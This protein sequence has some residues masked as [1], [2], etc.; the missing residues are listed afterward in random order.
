MA[1]HLRNRHPR[2]R[3]PLNF[4]EVLGFRGRFCVC[5][6]YFVNNHAS[7]CKG[8]PVNP[9]D[10]V[11]APPVGHEAK[12]NVLPHA[13]PPAVTRIPRF[14]VPFEGA[15]LTV[16]LS[17]RVH[18]NIPPH[19]HQVFGKA[20]IASISGFNTNSLY[21]IEKKLLALMSVPSATLYVTPFEPKVPPVPQD[22]RVVCARRAKSYLREGRLSK[23]TAA[24]FQDRPPLVTDEVINQLSALHPRSP[25]DS[26]FPSLPD[27]APIIKVT[28]GRVKACFKALN[29]D[30]APGCSA[31]TVSMLQ[32]VFDD[33]EGRDFICCVLAKIINGELKD[34]RDLILSSRLI[35]IAKPNGDVRPVAVGETLYK[36]AAAF[37]TYPLKEALAQIFSDI[38]FAYGVPGG[39]ERIVHSMQ[40]LAELHRGDPDYCIASADISNAFNSCNRAACFKEIL[41]HDSLSELLRI[42]HFAYSSPSLLYILDSK[43]ATR[44]LHSESGVKQGDILGMILF[45]LG[46]HPVL[47][48]VAAMNH[49]R[50]HAYADDPTF[51][52]KA[53]D[54]LN[55]VDLLE[56]ECRNKL[57]L[58]LNKRKT[59]FYF[60]AAKSLN[61]IS[62]G[63]RARI[64]EMGGEIKIGFIEIL[65]AVVG[66]D[67]DG[68]TEWVG[69]KVS[70]KCSKL[71][72][73]ILD[74]ESELVLPLHD[75]YI[76]LK[77]CFSQQ[78]NYLCRCI[79]PAIM[80]PGAQRWDECMIT[81]A[82][83]LC[84]S[85]DD[86]TKDGAAFRFTKDHLRHSLMIL[87]AKDGFPGLGISSAVVISETA[88]LGC[89]IESLPH[90]IKLNS[91]D[92][93]FRS[94]L[95][96]DVPV[97]SFV[98]HALNRLTTQECFKKTEL[99]PVGTVFS[100]NPAEIS[101]VF[102]R[103]RIPKPGE[104][105]KLH[106]LKLQKAF[107]DARHAYALKSILQMLPFTTTD[108]MSRNNWKRTRTFILAAMAKHSSL[109]LKM[110]R[111]S[112]KNRD[113][114][115]YLRTRSGFPLVAPSRVPE[116][117]FCGEHL[118]P[119]TCPFASYH[120][121][122]CVSFKGA[123]RY[124]L[125]QNI[126]GEYNNWCRQMNVHFSSNSAGFITKPTPREPKG[127]RPDGIVYFDD[128][129][130]AVDMT[131]TSPLAA[132]HFKSYI[133]PLHA[134]KNSE[135]DKIRWHE[136][137]CKEQNLS[138]VPVAVETSFGIGTHACALFKKTH[139]GARVKVPVQTFLH[140]L[141]STIITSVA[142]MCY[143]MLLR[144]EKRPHV[145]SRHPNPPPLEAK[146]IDPVCLA[147]DLFA[148]RV[149]TDADAF[150][151][152]AIT[153][154]PPSPPPEVALDESE[155][156]DIKDARP[157]LD[158]KHVPADEKERSVSELM[159]SILEAASG[160]P[161]VSP[162]ELHNSS[163][164]VGSS[165]SL[166]DAA[167]E[168][169]EDEEPLSIRKKRKT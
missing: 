7:K 166:A 129:K 116:Y 19:A 153:P 122:T 168:D 57:D 149:P 103:P 113:F 118:S 121:V 60:P 44:I 79:P 108:D 29:K 94:R 14:G 18:H 11:P 141:H 138:F 169:S 32:I 110:T 125:H 59:K 105:K 46:F 74:R 144:S 33:P 112:F 34:T 106:K 135:R 51:D 102:H 120:F 90:L 127:R 38:Q 1:L 16:N 142:N 72:D 162:A 40:S 20:A 87:P 98:K 81:I 115:F 139:E 140:S 54:V 52:G 76:L 96:F 156:E 147:R 6:A 88:W 21:D 56:S 89:L 27:N 62:P 163:S 134:V 95:N 164:S 114:A 97:G 26:K 146:T 85:D 91:A 119:R 64:Q 15:D 22:P 73:A 61:D 58:K 82:S 37:V 49:V 55:A 5:E 13:P 136:S 111:S 83:A 65:G 126:V 131:V 84:L 150:T 63:H 132:S 101:S 152:P 80:A 167:F 100:R 36:L 124:T 66:T 93:L 25:L 133:E 151:P 50:I 47:K 71:L 10:P 48:T 92:S 158:H 53:T 42:V 165:S 130:V 99:V 157:M 8:P 154:P 28:P 78:V 128:E 123:E 69:N 9:R 12:A 107:T 104:I 75:T 31:Q 160:C 41:K 23:A 68:M 137:V 30:A 148:G 145:P 39:C 155:F 45:C 109:A 117:C 2:Q 3:L 43:Q 86:E 4:E 24:L 143:A 70:Q 35:A 161:L 159:S 67:Y 77:N 17:Q